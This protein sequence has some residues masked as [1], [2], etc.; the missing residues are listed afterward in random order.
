MTTALPSTPCPPPQD[1]LDDMLYEPGPYLLRE[2]LELDAASALEAIRV[3]I[4]ADNWELATQLA[5]KAQQQFAQHEWAAAI[6]ATMRR[7]IGQRD[8]RFSAK[9]ALY[10]QRSLNVRLSS[11]DEQSL[12]DESLNSVPKFLRRRPEQGKDRF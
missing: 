8:K 7:L 4:E 12:G 1:L 9:E 2:L 3:A 10:A 6:I 5:E 11:V